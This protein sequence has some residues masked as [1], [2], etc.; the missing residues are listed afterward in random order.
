MGCLVCCHSDH[1][2]GHP[3]KGLLAKQAAA[4]A[5]A[6]SLDRMKK[7]LDSLRRVNHSL[8]SLVK[9]LTRKVEE[10]STPV[11]SRR[12]RA[13]PPLLHSLKH[14]S[15]DNKIVILCDAP[16]P[17][18]HVL[19]LQGIEDGSLLDMNEGNFSFNMPAMQLVPVQVPGMIS[20]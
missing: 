2:R 16:Q 5:K 15:T 6:A 11:V 4:L 7:E 10:L 13:G 18:E 8:R 9:E 19:T 1:F 17:A 14:Q 3:C 12:E 20:M